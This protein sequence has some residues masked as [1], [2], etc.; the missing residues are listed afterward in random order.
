MKRLAKLGMVVLVAIVG[1]GLPA[2]AS[3]GVSKDLFRLQVSPSGC[4]APRCATNA[5]CESFYGWGSECRNWSGGCSGWC[6]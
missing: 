6:T 3:V 4:S 5:Q 1:A 2:G